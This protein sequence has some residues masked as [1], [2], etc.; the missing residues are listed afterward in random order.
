MVSQQIRRNK[1][2]VI[3]EVSVVTSYLYPY[4]FLEMNVMN[5]EE[6]VSPT[7][8]DRTSSF[9]ISGLENSL[10]SCDYEEKFPRTLKCSQNYLM[11]VYDKI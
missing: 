7:F 4:N 1:I 9:K 8:S 6:K 10:K 5:M 11:F 2:T 3:H